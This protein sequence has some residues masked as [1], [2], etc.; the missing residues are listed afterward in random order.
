M[1]RYNE[2]FQKLITASRDWA[3]G[4]RE[5]L[6]ETREIRREIIEA[7]HARY[8]EN[9][10]LYRK[11]AQEQGFGQSASID[12]IKRHLM[13]DAGIFKSYE[14]G[15][16]N[17]GDYVSMT[18]WL[19]G[20]FCHRINIDVSDAD[21][22]DGWIEK[23]GQG[24]IHVV[25]SS[26]TSGT[27]SFVPRKR[28]NWELA[29]T[30][31]ITGITP[32]I[33]DRLKYGFT[34]RLFQSALQSKSPQALAELLGKRRLPGY[35]G[36]F[37]GFKKGRM[38]NQAL[39]EELAPLFGQSAFL[40]EI[41]VEASGLRALRRGTGT[42]G[43][44]LLAGKLSEEVVD[45]KTQNYTRLIDFIEAST[46]KGRKT[47]I[48][49]A[50]HQ[51]KELLEVMCALNRSL[52]LNRGSLALV[53]GGWKSF[54]GE[55]VSRQALVEVL[56]DKL[57]LER[58]KVVEGYSMTE[59][60][61]LMLRCRHGR[62]HIPPI[63]EPV[64]LDVEL[65]PTGSQEGEG[66]FGFMDPLALDY[67]GFIVSADYVRMASGECECGLAG[68]AVTRIGRMPGSETKGCGAI[69]GSVGT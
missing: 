61:L 12:A 20:I 52:S 33:L 63:V 15:W 69:M 54:T 7:N 32:Q 31:N 46:R 24:G 50:P 49:G 11:I 13:L 62:F 57:G 44:R 68:P 36:V 22:I 60:N 9:I 59:I 64:L 58:E 37:L 47:L 3:L 43:E 16:L 66:A 56:E 39:M 29:R 42:P 48:F 1:N 27:F 34:G 10:P 17:S 53:G 28:Q 67:P 14:Q 40:Y 38:G 51:F 41:P 35:D 19:A 26:G 6:E 25:Y 18:G 8:F 45:R 4:K 55:P 65:N 30:A 5:A 23:L 2:I 21:S